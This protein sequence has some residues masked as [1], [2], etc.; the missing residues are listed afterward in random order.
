MTETRTV[1]NKTQKLGE[2]ARYLFVGLAA[3]CAWGIATI[4]VE[5]NE[6]WRSGYLFRNLLLY[7]TIIL[8]AF[9][10]VATLL[11]SERRAQ[12][13]LAVISTAVTL[14]LCQGVFYVV[15]SGNPRAK[16]A[17]ASGKEFDARSGSRFIEETRVAG[18]KIDPAAAPGFWIET[19]GLSV[20]GKAIFPLAGMANRYQVMCNESGR[21]IKFKTDR[22]GFNNP[23]DVWKKPAQAV[24]IGDSWGHGV[25]VDRGED[26]AGH[27]RK[28]GV[29]SVNLSITG[30]GPLIE[31]ATLIEYGKRLKPK[32][33]LWVYYEENDLPNLRSEAGSPILMR[34]LKENGFDQNLASRQREADS[35]IE[36]FVSTSRPPASKGKRYAQWVGSFL[37][38][39]FF[40]DWL[41]ST[42][43]P[44]SVNRL[45]D[46]KS[47]AP[48]L[49]LL[50]DVLVRA[51]QVT[52]GWGGKLVFVYLPRWARY[53]Y[54]ESENATL[55][56]EVL[57]IAAKQGLPMLDFHKTLAA[58]PDPLTFF[59][60]RINGH[61]TADGNALLARELNAMIARNRWH[62]R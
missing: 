8:L 29:Q 47:Y 38:M 39:G 50:G 44:L 14:Y 17:K 2:I 1:N 31:L 6:Y 30:N 35:A 26:V 42:D 3:L 41:T 20:D 22:Y 48:D 45:L 15:S 28:L 32:Y 33:V 62:H 59:P 4:L 60:F 25:C 7:A 37:R 46:P 18:E 55:R 13:M 56:N 24:V 9:F 61:F 53:A 19:N 54:G 23:D 34:Y 52:E 16:I 11:N 10:V 21:W 57:N 51:R 40:G 49:Q 5:Y 43:H 12:L 58:H 36:Q 27:L